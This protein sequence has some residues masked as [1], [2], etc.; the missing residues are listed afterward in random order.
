VKLLLAALLLAPAARAATLDIVRRADVVIRVRATGTIV[1][2]DLFRLK[3]TIEGRVEEVNASTGVWRDNRDALATL[4]GNELAAMLDARGPQDTDVL[5]D[6]WG[7]VYT[8][9]PIR[10][11]DICYV[12]KSFLK[13]RSWVKPQAVLFEAARGLR[14]VGRVLTKDAHYLHRMQG[15]SGYT[16]T[17]W[18]VSN[19]AH[20]LTARPVSLAVDASGSRPTGAS[21]E[22][23]LPPRSD[24]PPGT[25]W[26]G[27][28]VIVVDHDVLVAPDASLIRDSGF[29]Y[30]PMRVAVGDAIDGVTE[31]L[32]GANENRPI[33][34][35]NDEE[36]N[37]AER[38]KPG[39]AVPPSPEVMIPGVPSESSR[40]AARPAPAPAPAPERQP[41]NDKDFGDD[42]YAH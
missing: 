12:L 33:L 15:V 17:Y 26:A 42:P 30:I 38:V 14:L 34:I 39:E 32:S 19:P 40:P 2:H 10:C 35:L 13:P 5:E 1:A 29:F 27:E 18:P 11:P 3:S 16:L 31:I 41:T 4:A 6:R 8:P 28:I 37:G 7:K 24:L 25:D 21:F 23:E 9:T 36:L 20:R 22:F